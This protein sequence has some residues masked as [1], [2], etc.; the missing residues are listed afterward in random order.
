M[1]DA[2]GVRLDRAGW[3]GPGFM[4]PGMIHA[5]MPVTNAVPYV[6]AAPPG[7]VTLADLLPVTG[8]T[9]GAVVPGVAPVSGSLTR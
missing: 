7:V 5:A 1:A 4:G 2:M 3:T 8:R 6:V 9:A